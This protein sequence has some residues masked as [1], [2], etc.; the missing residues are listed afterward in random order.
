M[1]GGA[2]PADGAD[3]DDYDPVVRGSDVPESEWQVGDSGDC[4]ECGRSLSYDDCQM[5]EDLPGDLMLCESCID[6]RSMTQ[7]P[8]ADCADDTDEADT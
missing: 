8:A 6:E 2:A 4:H 5:S 3:S 1:A 7:D